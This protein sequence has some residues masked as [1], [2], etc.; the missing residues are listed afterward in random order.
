MVIY[1]DHPSWRTKNTS[2]R[3]MEVKRR[4]DTRRSTRE[5]PFKNLTLATAN[6][7]LRATGFYLLMYIT[8][9]SITFLVGFVKY[10]V[11]VKLLHTFCVFAVSNSYGQSAIW[12]WCA[13]IE[14]SL[15]ICD[16][17]K[18]GLLF[19]TYAQESIWRKLVQMWRWQVKLILFCDSWMQCSFW[20][21]WFVLRWNVST[22]LAFR[23][24]DIVISDVGLSWTCY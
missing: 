8:F 24:D 20:S 16:F 17:R 7:V 11:F 23:A 10:V 13:S 14:W 15:G 3:W 9:K 5:N 1:H 6:V 21:H 19:Q 22:L 2:V 4:K 12:A 18:W